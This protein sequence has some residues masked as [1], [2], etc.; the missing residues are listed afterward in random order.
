MIAPRRVAVYGNTMALAGVA[1]ALQRDPMLEV[2]ILEL[3]DAT[4]AERLRT[5]SPRVI[6]FDL[7]HTDARTI[8]TCAE[9]CGDLLV[10]GIEANSD[11]MWL[12][13][14]HS[15][16]ALSIQ[17]LMQAIQVWPDPLHP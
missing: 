2:V 5:Q 7:A 6:L 13:R 12:G 14:E 16:R 11:R 3:G 17:D 4:L 1:L 10:I 9:H 8:L 15:E